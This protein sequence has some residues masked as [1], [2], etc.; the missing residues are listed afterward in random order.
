[1][2]WTAFE[3]LA[4]IAAL[5]LSIGVPV[6]RLN[7]SI[8]KLTVMLERVERD[9]ES[10]RQQIA[11]QKE[12]A[13]ASHEKLWRHNEEQDELLQRH[14]TRIQFL[15]RAKQDSEKKEEQ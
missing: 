6:I 13:R 7:S 11:A 1:M 4:A 3:T 8:T 5:F 14:E 2:E 10:N 9:V 12:A 15:E